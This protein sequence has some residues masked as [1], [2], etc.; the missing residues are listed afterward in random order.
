MNK[1]KTLNFYLIIG[2]QHVMEQFVLINI[3]MDLSSFIIY[4]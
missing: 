1:F 3:P 2:C 4:I